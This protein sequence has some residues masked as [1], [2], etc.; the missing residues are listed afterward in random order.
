MANE[1]NLIPI[2]TESEAREK[3][4]NGGKKSGEARRRKKS[5]KQTLQTALELEVTNTE[6]WNSLSAFGINP[7][8]IDY[9]NAIVV[10]MVS[11]AMAGNVQA[12]KEIRNL[13]GEDTDNERLK[14]QQKELLLKEQKQEAG[15]TDGA[16]SGLIEGL[17]NDIHE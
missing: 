5:L 3:G 10:A 13:I 8:N 4:S 15:E 17:K 6:I 2:R 11:Q 16:I 9:Q 14:L 12:F 1:K 7:E